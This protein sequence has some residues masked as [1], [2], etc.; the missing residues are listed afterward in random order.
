MAAEG[1]WSKGIGMVVYFTLNE[2][3]RVR[4]VRKRMEASQLDKGYSG[5][6]DARASK[7]TDKERILGEI[8][9]K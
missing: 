1:Y 5:P 2:V 3:D 8:A 7:Q 9:D 6:E 4:A